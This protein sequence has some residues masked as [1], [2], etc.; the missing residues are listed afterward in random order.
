MTLN[1]SILFVILNLGLSTALASQGLQPRVHNSAPTFVKF[2]NEA[3]G[4]PLDQQ[5]EKF[6]Q[7][8]YSTFPDFYDFKFKKWQKQGKS[9]REGLSEQFSQYR[10]IHENFSKRTKTIA[11]LIASNLNSFTKEFPDFNTNLDIYIIHSLGELDGGIRTIDGK[12]YF[13]IGI[14]AIAK[15]H[16]EILNDSPFFHHELFHVYHAQYFQST[17]GLWSSLWMEGLPTYVS[18][19]LN[20]GVSNADIL[21]DVPSDLVGKCE[22]DIN[23][24]WNDVFR[25]LQSTK[26]EDYVKYFLL[27]SLDPRIPR[28]AGY[29]LGY[30]VAKEL[31]KTYRLDELAKLD[32]SEVQRLVSETVEMFVNK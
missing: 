24:L 30:L 10:A 29:Y 5:I 17:G 23:F 25:L 27:A 22:K 16:R 8:V 31:A 12:S 21:L 15:Y 11:S 18:S 7:V 1:L 13:I 3:S 2:W 9:K 26:N 32:P 20:P 4:L 19:A 6:D 14:D 28:R